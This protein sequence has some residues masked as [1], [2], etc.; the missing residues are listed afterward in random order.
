MRNLWGNYDSP[1]AKNSLATP[2][3]QIN[4]APV[5][6]AAARSIYLCNPARPVEGVAESAPS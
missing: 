4:W 3:R 6:F 1:A 5:D 2:P